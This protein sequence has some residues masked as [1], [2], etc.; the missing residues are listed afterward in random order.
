MGRDLY[1]TITGMR[2]GNAAPPASEGDFRTVDLPRPLTELGV[3]QV[4]RRRKLLGERR[5]ST[6]ISSIAARARETARLVTKR[7]EDCM[8]IL[9]CLYTP[10]GPDGDIMERDYQRYGSK[11]P[12]YY[13]GHDFDGVYSK[14]MRVAGAEIAPFVM[15]EG[16]LIM[17][18]HT[19]FT[20][21][22]VLGTLRALTVEVARHIADAILG[23]ELPEAGA[24][25]V[26]V[27]EGE[28]VE[29]AIHG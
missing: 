15:P 7:G 2:H 13:L 11:S 3:S 26:Y 28:V 19:P 29:F 20:N 4:D 24:F 23:F 1:C 18:G 21:L 22:A 12:S 6:V 8:H 25:T 5:Y 16:D 17:F 9:P 14:F 27:K 10:E